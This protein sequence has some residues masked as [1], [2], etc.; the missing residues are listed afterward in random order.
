MLSGS[1]KTTGVNMNRNKMGNGHKLNGKW[2]E[3]Q[4]VFGF[5]FA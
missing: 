1:I 4:C 2:A 5:V 3:M